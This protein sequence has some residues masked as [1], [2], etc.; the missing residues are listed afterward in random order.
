MLKIE[1]CVLLIV[2]IQGKLWNVMNE[3][4]ALLENTLKLIKGFQVLGVPF[5]LTEQN[6][7]GLGPTLPEITQLIPETTAIPK[8]AFSCCKE[9]EFMDALKKLNRTQILIC[10]IETHICLY[11]TSMELLQK[12]YEVHVVADAVSSRLV[13]NRDIALGRMQSEGVKLTVVEM[14]QYE[15]LESATSP[16]F[17]DMLRLVK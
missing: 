13:R 15:L 7:K 5:I 9:I 4:E 1:N 12:G 6:P 3:K 8:F 16:K 17:K 14:A 10:G 11:Q 2:D